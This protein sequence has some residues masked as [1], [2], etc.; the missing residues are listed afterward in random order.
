MKANYKVYQLL[1]FRTPSLLLTR[2]E[3][4]NLCGTVYRQGN[5]IFTGDGNTLLSPVG[6]RV[7]VFDL[8][9]CAYP[10]CTASNYT[11][12][13]LA[14]SNKSSTFAFENRKNI[15]AIALSPDSN[16]LI[17]VDEGMSLKHVA[18]IKHLCLTA[19]QM[20]VHYLSISKEA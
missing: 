9:K 2:F 10:Q 7:S 8:V 3:F 13:I 18:I 6:N 14:T 16:V 15:S 5:I 20:D 17:S 19:L 4:S 11:N 12:T 1:Y